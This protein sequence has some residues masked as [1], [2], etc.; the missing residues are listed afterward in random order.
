MTN[1]SP[2]RP[3]PARAGTATGGRPEAPLVQAIERILVSGIAITSTA[4][5]DAAASEELTLG[6][7]RALAIV[8]ASDRL[9]IGELALRLA[10][11]VPSASRLVR[12]LE[13]RGLVAPQ[14]DELD[15]RATVIAMTPTGEAV[16][17]AV[18]D[19]RR[20]LIADAVNGQVLDADTQRAIEALADRM[21]AFA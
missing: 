11:A 12:R 18:T 14:R 16:F 2:T 17:D 1:N 3:T 13:D 10:I 19:R 6:Q 20:A 4:I 9:R 21:N 8:H 15:R 7:W 5:A